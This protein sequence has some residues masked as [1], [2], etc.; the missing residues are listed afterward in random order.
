MSEQG[1]S[2]QLA[3]ELAMEQ[4]KTDELVA[5]GSEWH[6]LV[7]LTM[8]IM[9]LLASIGGLLSGITAHESAREK[10]AEIINLTILEGDRVSVEVLK[11]KHDI[12]ISLG[13]TPDETEL[14]AIQTFE[15]E[16]QEKREEVTREESLA[17]VI[18]QTHL[19]FS[20]SVTILAAGIS[21]SGMSIVLDMKW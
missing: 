7:A 6:R 5:R 17:Q 13:E 21:L 2:T 11:A 16:I 9:A 10:S 15:D 8:L 20:I 14:Q 1:E 19:I 4:M 12:L 3:N 18:G